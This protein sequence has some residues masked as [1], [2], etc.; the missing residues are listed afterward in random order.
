MGIGNDIFI[1]NPNSVIERD[2]DM[3][4]ASSHV[5]DT[6]DCFLGL[7]GA[8]AISEVGIFCLMEVIEGQPTQR[9][10]LLPRHNLS[11]GRAKPKFR[12]PQGFSDTLENGMGNSFVSLLHLSHTQRSLEYYGSGFDQMVWN[13]CLSEFEKWFQRFPGIMGMLNS[14]HSDVSYNEGSDADLGFEGRWIRLKFQV[15]IWGEEVLVDVD[16]GPRRSGINDGHVFWLFGSWLDSRF[17][18]TR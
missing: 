3:D 8:A 18:S 1:W 10:F 14:M 16:L 15:A 9:P 11:I 7:G 4:R 12:I 17:L 2:V 5:Q 13:V 6:P